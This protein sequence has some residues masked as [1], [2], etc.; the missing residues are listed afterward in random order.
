MQL[1]C[2]M[3]PGGPGQIGLG[4]ARIFP[5]RCEYRL[6]E[7]DGELR[8]ARKTVVLLQSDRPLYNLTFII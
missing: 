1:I 5:A 3:R 2:E 6:R 4:E 8:I 7:E